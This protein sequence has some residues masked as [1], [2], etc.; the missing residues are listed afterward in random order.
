MELNKSN[1]EK[2]EWNDDP[3]KEDILN[4]SVKKYNTTLGLNHDVKL[5]LIE[6]PTCMH[7]YSYGNGGINC[8]YSFNRYDSFDKRR[9]ITKE[10]IAETR[11]LTEFNGHKA[12]WGFSVNEYNYCSSEEIR[13]CVKVVITCSGREVYE[14]TMNADIGLASAQAQVIINKLQE[15]IPIDFGFIDFEKKVIGME[16]SIGAEKGR[17][18]NY[19]VKRGAISLET[20]NGNYFTEDIL[21]NLINWF[22]DYID[23]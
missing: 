15:N 1:Y 9:I 20:E 22:P 16:V 13:G 6:I 4:G 10:R 23:D 12:C 14:F 5:S 7:S 21:S 18:Y 11:S 8:M 19:D 17:I 2:L 3:H